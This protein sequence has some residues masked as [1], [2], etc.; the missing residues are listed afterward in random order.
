M[1]IDLETIR[2]SI[3][4]SGEVRIHLTWGRTGFYR[5][6]MWHPDGFTIGTA[7]GCGYDKGGAALGEALAFLFGPELAALPDSDMHYVR[8][9]GQKDKSYK[10]GQYGMTRICDEKGTRI[11]LD[12]GCGLSCMLGVL[13]RLGFSNVREISTGKNS[14]LILATGLDSKRMVA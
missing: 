12:G 4:H 6:R 10:E 13:T 8:E 5:A 2:S 7:G 9:L 11:I 14:T 3:K 1:Q